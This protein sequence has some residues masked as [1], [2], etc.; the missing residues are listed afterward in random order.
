MSQPRLDAFTPL[1]DAQEWLRAL[2][3]EGAEC[4]CCTQFAK[5]YW[6]PLTSA[7]ARVLILLDRWTYPGEYV[8]LEELMNA[9]RAEGYRWVPVRADEAKLRFWGLVELQDSQREDGSKRVGYFRITPTGRDFVNG[10]ME[11]VVNE[12][13]K[14]GVLEK[15]PEPLP[16]FGPEGK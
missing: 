2:L 13:V 12:L 10:H 3:D 9:K 16:V 5:V 15:R 1:G 6:R 14:R 4:P 7:M 8:K 11:E